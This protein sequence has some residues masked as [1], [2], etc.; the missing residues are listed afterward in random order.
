M[1]R[2]RILLSDGT[3]DDLEQKFFQGITLKEMGERYG[4]RAIV[5]VQFYDDEEQ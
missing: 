2:V 1:K 3:I 4:N 5:D